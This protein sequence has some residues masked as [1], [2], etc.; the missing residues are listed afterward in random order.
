MYGEVRAAVFVKAPDE[1][2]QRHTKGLSASYRA[3]ADY[4]VALVMRRFFVP[5]V[6]HRHLFF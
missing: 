6:E 2:R 5:P 1:E 4:S 3:V